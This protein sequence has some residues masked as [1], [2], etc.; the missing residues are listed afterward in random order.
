MVR[1]AA[2]P[3]KFETQGDLNRYIKGICN[4]LRRDKAKGARLYVAELTWMLY[5]NALDVKEA[6]EEAMAKAVGASFT[7]T[8]EAPY[9]WRDWA[10]T[11]DAAGNGEHR[12]SLASGAMGEFLAFVNDELFPYLRSLG[13]KPNATA[14]QRVT[15]LIFGNKDSTVLESET[16]LLDALDS[17]D[18]LGR[19]E[20][21]QQH[22]F[23]ISQAFEGL[24]PFLGEKKNDGGQFFTP[25]EVARVMVQ[26]VNPRLGKTVYDPCAG[27]AGF[28][29]EAYKHLI[30]QGPAPTELE[31]LRRDVLWGREY[32]NE[33]LPITLANMILHDIETP[34]IWHGNT[35]TG[36]ATSDHLWQDAPAQYDYI[37]T[38]PPFGSKEGKDAQAHFAYKIAKAQVL[39]LQ[40]IV[41]SLAP[42]GTCG[43]VID[44]GVMFQTITASVQT[45]RKLLNECDLFCVVSLP[46]GVFVNAG[47]GV[48]TNILFFKKG[49]ST[50]R[51]WYYDLSD[52][53]VNKSNPLTRDDFDDF[54]YRV[55]LDADD[56]ERVSD[57]SWF[58]DIDSIK[59]RT[60]DL[61]AIN[62][63]ANDRS[64]PRTTSELLDELKESRDIMETALAAIT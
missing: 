1:R 56:P 64:D 50:E 19:S 58:V 6:E 45:K 55:A 21:S 8:L 37:L 20:V 17:V 34:R 42:G 22:L 14:R 12:A 3:R 18:V 60:Y 31:S 49:Q 26:V 38:N 15:A 16:T 32:A 62:P 10:A 27:T 48:K 51:V 53:K 9:R 47:A 39:F 24:L 57:R 35:L 25:R 41:D 46:K 11:P 43:M 33:A 63:T 5:L 7:P 30:L 36:V 28:L 54:L 29:I 2:A 13:K 59:S 4:I 23:T 61:K 44:E 52:R 40:H